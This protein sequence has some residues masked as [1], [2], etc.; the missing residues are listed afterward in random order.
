LPNAK[1][2]WRNFPIRVKNRNMIYSKIYSKNSSVKLNYLPPNHKDN[3]YINFKN[4]NN[5]KIT[6]KT[7]S[8]III[9]PCH[10][11]MHE[12]EITK[13]SKG[14]LKIIN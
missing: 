9:L 1:S 13:L 3:C 5:L 12:S 14:L 6:E 10:P 7:S 8:E 11:Y 4:V 2:A